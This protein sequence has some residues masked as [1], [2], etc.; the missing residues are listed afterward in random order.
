MPALEKRFY[1]VSNQ[2][3]AKGGLLRLPIDQVQDA[4][5]L[6]FAPKF[7]LK[8]SL[9]KRSVIAGVPYVQELIGDGFGAP[10]GDD[11]ERFTIQNVLGS[12]FKQALVLRND[13]DGAGANK[14]QGMTF[15][16]NINAQIGGM[17][18]G[19]TSIH[20]VHQNTFSSNVHLMATN[21]NI[22]RCFIGPDRRISVMH[23][24]VAR[25][26]VDPLPN[27]PHIIV[28]SYSAV[29]RKISCWVDGLQIAFAISDVLDAPSGTIDTFAIN[30]APGFA[31][32]S[33]TLY[34]GDTAV[35]TLPIEG[36]GGVPSRLPLL[37]SLF[38]TCGDYY[39]IAVTI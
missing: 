15:V 38:K 1:D 3:V 6:D 8:P 20:V 16:S 5:I 12:K 26:S 14:G 7:W 21:G 22:I 4:V 24:G 33:D 35:S 30:Y 31:L 17:T 10:Y 37:P 34:V 18:G 9:E 29:T 23:N 39:G 32:P 25:V 13:N 19:Y 11:P 2:V 36:G 27:N 28:T